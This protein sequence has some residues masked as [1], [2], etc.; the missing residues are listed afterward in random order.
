VFRS[1]LA[2]PI[3]DRLAPLQI[4]SLVRKAKKV[5]LPIESPPPPPPLTFFSDADHKNSGG[6][7]DPNKKEV[8]REQEEGEA[9]GGGD[10]G[11][12]PHT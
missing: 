3:D 6:A 8:E 1:R 9:T 11:P 7:G 5:A 4:S 2:F 10:K 12:K